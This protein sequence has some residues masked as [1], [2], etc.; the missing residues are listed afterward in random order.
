M[1]RKVFLKVDDREIRTNDFVK[2]VLVSVVEGL[3]KSLDDVPKQPKSIEIV[4]Q[5][6]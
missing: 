6:D 5:E 2:R 3:V 1:G 4:I